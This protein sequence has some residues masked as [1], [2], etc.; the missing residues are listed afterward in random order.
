MQQ[1]RIESMWTLPQ[2]FVYIFVT[3][4][5]YIHIFQKASNMLHNYTHH[6]TTLSHNSTA[7]VLTGMIFLAFP[8]QIYLLNKSCG[9]QVSAANIFLNLPRIVQL[10]IVCLQEATWKTNGGI[11]VAQFWQKIGIMLHVKFD[12]CLTHFT[13][14]VFHC[15]TQH[16][17]NWV[18]TE[19]LC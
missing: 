3:T 15:D 17:A 1:H 8:L 6:L 9:S 16:T 14:T 12:L 4:G 13:V 18:I 7:P 2:E 11:N 19:L 5:I 10:L